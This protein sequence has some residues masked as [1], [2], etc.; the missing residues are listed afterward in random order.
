MIHDLH[1]LLDALKSGAL[2]EHRQPNTEL[3]QSWKQDVGKKISAHG[4]NLGCPKAWLVVGVDDNGSI[5]GYGEEWARQT[6]RQIS[7]HVNQYL[8][9]SQACQSLTCQELST[10]CWVILL[11]VS[12]P[13]AV[14]FW[15]RQPYKLAGTTSALMDPAEVMEL[16]ICLP[17]LHDY[18]RQAWNG[19]VDSTLVTK[20]AAAVGSRY[21]QSD[22]VNLASLDP[23]EILTKVRILDTNTTRILFG[24]CRFRIVIFDSAGN[25]VS[26][27]TYAGLSHLLLSPDARTLL[28]PS[29]TDMGNTARTSNRSHFPQTALMEGLANAVA[30]AAYFERD[31]DIIIE[32]FPDRILISNLCLAESTY[33]ANKWFSRSHHTVNPL[34]ME[35]LRLAGIVDELGRG[36][37]L[38]YRDSIVNGLKPPVVE[39]ERA[40]RLSRWRLVLYGGNSDARLLTLQ[41]R[42]RQHY[43]DEQKVLIACALVL[44]RDKKVSEIRQHVSGDSA[45]MF[46]EV[47][48]DLRGPVFYFE[49]EDRLVLNRWVRILIGEGKESKKFS[50]REEGRVYD[51]AYKLCTKYDESIITPKRLRELG[52]MGES[53]AAKTASSSLLKKWEQEGK[54]QQLRKGKYK[55]EP[56]VTGDDF[57]RL[58]ELFTMGRDT[59]P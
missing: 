50:E 9:P 14:V 32:V 12:N 41:R 19:A 46:A 4:N 20:F 23:V 40:G 18:S 55:F 48:S 58:L 43:H 30:H 53:N 42:L 27:T 54:V 33:F 26:N 45:Q 39:I 56:R 7:D 3:K 29:S 37:N 35:T 25:P 1:E 17:G 44:W 57:K 52:D 8:D 22:L 6:E 13:G 36:K 10:G 5:C 11:E 31:G 28:Q 21:Q 15:N 38:I 49:E 24:D 34:L 51:L 2:S 47:L 59:S 16:T